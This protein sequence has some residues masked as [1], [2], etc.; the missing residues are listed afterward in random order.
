MLT[1]A[2]RLFCMGGPPTR[3]LLAALRHDAE[4]RRRNDIMAMLPADSRVEEHMPEIIS[5]GNH[6]L[7]R[8]L[9]LCRN[10]YDVAI[11]ELYSSISC[12][13]IL[14]SFKLHGRGDYHGLVRRLALIESFVFSDDSKR[15]QLPDHRVT[16]QH[17]IPVILERF[18]RVEE[19]YLRFSVEAFCNSRTSMISILATQTQQCVENLGIRRDK[20]N[21]NFPIGM[22]FEHC[23]SSWS[24]SSVYPK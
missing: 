7:F 15:L 20:F 8:L 17:N 21:V 1:A 11:S 18:P 9:T 23:I 3:S 4:T 10:W 24:T 2:Q 5:A 12:S 16:S 14:P 6:A 13:P 22:N 19:A